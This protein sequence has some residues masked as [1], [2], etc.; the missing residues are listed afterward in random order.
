MNGVFVEQRLLE[1]IVTFLI[2][3]QLAHRFDDKDLAIAIEFLKALREHDEKRVALLYELW[4]P[5][6]QEALG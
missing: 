3:H 2:R 6:L 1:H 5:D 4:A